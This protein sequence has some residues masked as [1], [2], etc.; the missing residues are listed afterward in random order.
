[1]FTFSV[2]LR[3]AIWPLIGLC[4]L[5]SL[6]SGT[7]ASA[8]AEPAGLRPAAQS[9]A[10]RLQ[11]AAEADNKKT[12]S[13]SFLS[14]LDR[15][16]PTNPSL[17][18][19]C[20]ADYIAIRHATISKALG[21]REKQELRGVRNNAILTAK[22]SSLAPRLVPVCLTL[23]RNREWF[24]TDGKPT[25]PA[26]TRY[27]FEP[28]RVIWQAYL[29]QGWQLQPLANFSKLYAWATSKTPKS[30]VRGYAEELLNLSVQRSKTKRS[31]DSYKAFE[32]YFRFADGNPPWVSAMATASALQA[33]AKVS[34]YLND[35][36]YANLGQELLPAFQKQPSFGTRL[37]FS[38]NGQVT[39][40]HY[41]IYSQDR[42]QLVGNA[43][44]FSLIGL[45]DFS[46]STGNQLAASLYTAGE[47]ELRQEIHQY[48]T[49][50]WSFYNLPQADTP[51]QYSDVHYHELFA[52]FLEELCTR[53]Q[54]ML[55]C[56]TSTHFR[57]Y[58]EEPL[59]ISKIRIARLKGQKKVILRFS[60]DK[61]G[62]TKISIWQGK[63]ITDQV[64]LHLPGG[65][66][67]TVLSSR[68]KGQ[69]RIKFE[70]HSANGISSETE[71]T[72]AL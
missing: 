5:L 27:R 54:I 12:T 38:K 9:A 10:G 32:Y 43:F 50:T 13:D 49:G 23:Q 37:S 42:H 60:A 16:A 71:I 67:S 53:T 39:R 46:S 57:S 22:N 30:A 33:L 17:V 14:A 40:N 6:I 63:K 34:I 69:Q 3:N 61:P 19:I 48:D 59:K 70:L 2:K 18:S 8:L 26:T 55:Y 28:S 44:T 45:Y 41:L 29:G 66:A 68:R 72:R 62:S 35:P 36:K 25:A 4:L 31:S 56:D 65:P 11:R 51:G 20:R 58:E 64:S 47:N 15:V 52:D 1:M 21:N 7:A 24:I